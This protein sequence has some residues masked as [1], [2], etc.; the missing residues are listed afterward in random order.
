MFQSECS[1]S[2]AAIC[3]KGGGGFYTR[4]GHRRHVEK[5]LHGTCIHIQ[6]AKKEATGRI[7]NLEACPSRILRMLRLV[8][9]MPLSY[10]IAEGKRALSAGAD[11]ETVPAGRVPYGWVFGLRRAR[12]RDQQHISWGGPVGGREHQIIIAYGLSRLWRS[13]P[14][15]S[16]Q[17]PLCTLR[18]VTVL[19][20]G[21][22]AA[23]KVIT[24]DGTG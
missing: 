5:R 8:W 12:L 2:Q 10:V 21:I 4:F 16:C 1:F 17:T 23:G 6:S 9:K 15:P 3:R 22:L 18:F 24:T 7:D 14:G 11:R 19:P 13:L 20:T